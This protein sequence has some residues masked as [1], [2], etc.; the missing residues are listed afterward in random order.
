MTNQDGRCKNL[1]PASVHVSNGNGTKTIF[2]LEFKLHEYWQN[3]SLKTF[4]PSASVIFDTSYASHATNDHATNDQ[5]T[6]HYHVPL[7]ITP[8]SYNTYKGT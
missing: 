6:S 5:A 7:V 8:F 3:F 4:F 1:T 2:K